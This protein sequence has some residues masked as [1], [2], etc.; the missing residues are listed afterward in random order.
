M[1]VHPH[2]AEMSHNAQSDPPL[3]QLCATPRSRAQQLPLRLPPQG[4]TETNEVT[5]WPP[6]D[7]TTKM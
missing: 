7:W 3:V 4:A 1:S 6:P 5:S 2:S